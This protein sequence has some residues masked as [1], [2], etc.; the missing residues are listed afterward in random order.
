MSE[1]FWRIWNGES[2]E[3]CKQIPPGKVNCII[4]DPPF[5]VDNQSNMAVTD[6]GKKYAR[7]I[8]NDEDPEMAWAVFV[9]V[10]RILLTKTADKCDVYVFTSYQVLDVWLPRTIELMRAHDFKFKA[11]LH[12]VKDGPGMGDL[13]YPFGMGSEYI[14]GFRKGSGHE[15]R[16]TR[17]NGTLHHSQ[18]RPKDLLHPHEKPQALLQELIRASTDPGDFIV[19]PFGGSGSTVRA[20][21]SEGRSCLAVEYDRNNYEIAVEALERTEGALL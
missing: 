17:K 4:T 7:K 6:S 21:K 2:Q 9:D 18:V 3:L 1:P 15:L 12:W 16:T 11:I 20:A 5:G 8:A 10:M 13:T 14:L 19:D